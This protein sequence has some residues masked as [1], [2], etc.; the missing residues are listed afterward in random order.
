MKFLQAFLQL[1]SFQRDSEIVRCIA[2]VIERQVS[3]L[4]RLLSSFSTKIHVGRSFKVPPLSITTT[5]PVHEIL[6]GNTE[7]NNEGLD[8]QNC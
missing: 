1:P 8:K 7:A 2:L 4:T 3:K 5:E 6:V